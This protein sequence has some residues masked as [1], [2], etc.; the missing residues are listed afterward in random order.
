MHNSIIQKS[1]ISRAYLS[2]HLFNF[3][4]D[5]HILS[6]LNLDV[7]TGEDFFQWFEDLYLVELYELLL[8]FFYFLEMKGLVCYFCFYLLA[9]IEE[10]DYF[11]VSKEEN[12]F[13]LFLA[14]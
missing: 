9:V 11:I 14:E 13:F 6:K 5:Y 3:F 1:Q 7:F 12:L 10:V 8:E 2:T 4:I